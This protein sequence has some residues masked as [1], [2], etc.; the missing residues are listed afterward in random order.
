[1]HQTLSLSQT[2]LPLF[3]QRYRKIK[4]S[5]LLNIFKGKLTEATRRSYTTHA[6]C[7]SNGSGCHLDVRREKKRSHSADV[8]WI[9]EKHVTLTSSGTCLCQHVLPTHSTYPSSLSSA[10]Y[11]LCGRGLVMFWKISYFGL[12]LLRY[13]KSINHVTYWGHL[14]RLIYIS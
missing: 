2:T 10:H 5:Y 6:G 13:V 11:G 4:L 14:C 1:M 12:K 7:V 3:Q 9:F 8:L